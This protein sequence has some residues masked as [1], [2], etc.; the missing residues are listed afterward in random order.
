MCVCVNACALPADQPPTN[1][2]THPP[3]NQPT[4]PPTKPLI[5]YDWS[6]GDDP[7]MASRPND[8]FIHATDESDLVAPP[9]APKQTTHYNRRR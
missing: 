8:I 1:P 3:T 6:K 4:N 5:R 7:A 9:A 2:P